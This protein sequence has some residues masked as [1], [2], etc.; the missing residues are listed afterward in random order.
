MPDL[1][2][3]LVPSM[4]D[5]A[6]PFHVAL[7]RQLRVLQAG[8]SVRKL[9]PDGLVGLQFTDLFTI[10]TPRIATS[11]EAF[12]DRPRDLFLLASRTRPGL[13]LR[14]QV[15]HEPGAD[16]LFFVGSPWMTETTAFAALGLTV[17]DFAVSD[18][19]VDYVLLLQTQASALDEARALTTQL[20]DTAEQLTHQAFHDPLT[21]LPNRALLLSHLRRSMDHHQAPGG[22]SVVLILDLDDFKAVNDSYG[23]SAGDE[24]LRVV[25]DRL[26]TVARDTDLVARLDGDQFALVPQNR[27]PA[28]RLDEHAAT[29][30]ARRLL[31]ALSGSVAL[32]SWPGITVPLSASIGIAYT[33]RDAD[34]P[35]DLLRNADL[36][37]YAAKANGKGAVPALPARAAGQGARPAGTRQA[38]P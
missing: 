13:I 9:H 10:T 32:Q 5:I 36:A 15:L 38:A 4:L 24:V 25:G 27:P 31:K 21:G 34:T 22:H 28:T 20:H 11:F 37:M 30:L 16:V 33:G 2:H 23:H 29:K 3:T 35:E 18:G 17:G 19:V 6:F 12:V 1:R 14:G 26:R 7:D 8:P